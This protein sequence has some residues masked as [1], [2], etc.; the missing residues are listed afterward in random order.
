MPGKIFE[1]SEALANAD[2]AL[3]RAK[4]EGRGTACFFDAETDKRLRVQRALQ[5]DLRS[6]ISRGELVIDYQP[7]AHVNGE[8]TGFEALVRWPHPERGMISPAE[9]IPLAEESEAI[10][11]MGEWALR[12]ACR[13]AAAGKIPGTVAVNLSPV[14]F[15]HVDLVDFLSR[16][17]A[18]HEVDP[19][20]IVLEVTD[21]GSPPL[22]RYG[23]VVV[24]VR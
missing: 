7:Q 8:I 11:G 10:V 23:R 2:A 18:K 19:S 1:L 21:N 5:Q 15:K 9:F 22:T 4:S 3:Y 12:T 24:T 20:R 13:D 14:Q 6:A 16:L 17:V